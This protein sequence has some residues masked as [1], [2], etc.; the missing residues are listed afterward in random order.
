MSLAPFSVKV[1]ARPQ[2]CLST[3]LAEHLRGEGK[4]LNEVYLTVRLSAQHLNG[5]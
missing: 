3:S 4:I 5:H 1:S 2:T